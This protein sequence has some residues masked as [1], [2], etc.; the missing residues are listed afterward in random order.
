MKKCPKCGKKYS[1]NFTICPICD[2][3]FDGK[4]IE[5]GVFPVLRIIGILFII[6]G[7]AI[8]IY[9]LA[10]LIYG[11]LHGNE[12]A[13]ETG[14]PF[15]S[16]PEALGIMIFVGI[17]TIVAFPLLALGGYFFTYKWEKP[18]VYDKDSSNLPFY[19]SKCNRSYDSSWK[20]CLKCGK[21]LVEKSKP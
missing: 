16:G 2:V 1:D 4:P 17:A 19:C 8:A 21:P 5:E 6:A 11:M 12:I 3:Y 14:R 7:F 9:A 13:K 15:G 20:V 10:P 18:I